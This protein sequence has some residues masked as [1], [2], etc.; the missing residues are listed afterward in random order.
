[1]P[2]RKIIAQTF[3]EKACL[4]IAKHFEYYPTSINQQIKKFNVR[5]K[6]EQ[7]SEIVSTNYR[8]AKQ[9][10]LDFRVMRSLHSDKIFLYGKG[11]LTSIKT[12]YSNFTTDIQY[13]TEQE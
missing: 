12:V 4:E 7:Y 3:E 1:M 9:F 13:I 11:S 10:D 5:G 2:S 6:K 8:K